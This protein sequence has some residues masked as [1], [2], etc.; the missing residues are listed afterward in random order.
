MMTL[1][2][3]TINKDKGI[4]HATYRRQ[5]N[6]LA[7]RRC[8]KKKAQAIQSLQDALAAQAETIDLLHK[9]R[10]TW[11]VKERTYNEYIAILSELLAKT[12]LELKTLTQ[13]A[14]SHLDL[15]QRQDEDTAMPWTTPLTDASAEPYLA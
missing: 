6:L 12:R 4:D 15:D 9:Q 2:S 13:F 5:Q 8:R 1:R 10:E 3:N 11:L 7:A 14:D